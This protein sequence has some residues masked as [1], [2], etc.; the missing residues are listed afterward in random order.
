MI[1]GRFLRLV[2]PMFCGKGIMLPRFTVIVCASIA[3]VGGEMRFLFEIP[4]EFWRCTFRNRF[5]F[6]GTN[7]RYLFY[8]CS[9]FGSLGEVFA[10]GGELPHVIFVVAG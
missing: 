5:R 1:H 2:N 7:Y 8:D 6:L 10:R 9:S 4:P 3:V